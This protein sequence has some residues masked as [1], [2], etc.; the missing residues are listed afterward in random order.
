MLVNV[1]VAAAIGLLLFQG[2]KQGVGDNPCL[3]RDIRSRGRCNAQF[4]DKLAQFSLVWGLFGAILAP[5]RV[6]MGWSIKRVGGL[7]VQA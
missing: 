4:L 2:R 6:G 1:V 5:A 3:E 7:A